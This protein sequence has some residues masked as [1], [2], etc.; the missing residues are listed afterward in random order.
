MKKLLF[1]MV[2]FASHLACAGEGV[3]GYWTTIDDETNT[4]K[5][6]VQIYEYQG[7]VYGRVVEL[8]QNKEAVAKLPDEPKIKGLDVIWDMEQ[9]KDKFTGGKILDPKT[10]KVYACDMWRDGDKLIVR[11]KIAFLGRNQ[12]W[13]PNTTFKPETETKPVPQ[14]PRLK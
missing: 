12:T 7:K 13:E 1:L 2:L 5:S 4:P 6:V 9:K 8:F 3:E 11:G 10:G 14:K